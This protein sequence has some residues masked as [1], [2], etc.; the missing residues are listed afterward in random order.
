MDGLICV[1]DLTPLGLTGS[2]EGDSGSAVV[3]L[4][5]DSSIYTYEQIGIVSG[6]RCNDERTPSVLTNIGH[7]SVLEF[8]YQISK[9]GGDVIYESPLLKCNGCKFFYFS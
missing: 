4:N 6:G 7:K 9:F 5:P 3:T 8:I 1:E 2:C